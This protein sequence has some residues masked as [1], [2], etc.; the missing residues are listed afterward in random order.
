[1]TSPEHALQDAIYAAVQAGEEAVRVSS[2][3]PPVG[4][5][6]LDAGGRLVST[7]ATEPAGG[8]HA[9]AV[10]LDAAGPS[11]EGGTLVVTLEPCSHTGRTGPCTQRIIDAG[12]ARVVY[13]VTDPNPA[14]AGGS[15]VLR[16]AG[17]DVTQDAMVEALASFDAL[18]AWLHKQETGRP[19]VTW[20]YAASLDGYVAASDGTSQWIT[21]EASRQHAHSR[22]AVVDAIIVGSGTVAAD[23]PT[24]SARYAD[25]SP[26]PRSPL[27]CVMGVA[28][29][30]AEAAI[31]TSPGGFQHL[32]TRDPAE[33]LSQLP[34]ALHVIVEGGP[35]VA[36]AFLEAGLVD[37]IDAYIA[38]VVLGGGRSITDG[39]DVGTL[40]AAHRFRVDFH[41]QLGDDAFLRLAPPPVD[42]PLYEWRMYP[43]E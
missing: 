11:A 17:V 34:D 23:N 13:G 31:R 28:E 41:E 20:K 12:V 43:E 26:R 30:P 1:M 21:G 25:G 9:E 8:R 16:D 27:A 22:R 19:L 39:A 5:V 14:A 3:N 24:L 33:A 10:A 42:E 18:R 2:P 15:E 4:S 37:E 29:V 35:T 6:L 40:A 36:G 38:P 32:R 7:G